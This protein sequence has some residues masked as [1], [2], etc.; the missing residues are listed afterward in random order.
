[1]EQRHSTFDFLF[2]N[3]ANYVLRKMALKL[4]VGSHPIVDPIEQKEDS[5]PDQSAAAKTEK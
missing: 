5:D 1:L 2:W 3:L 4:A